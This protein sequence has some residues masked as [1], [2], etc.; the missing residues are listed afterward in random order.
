[1]G[2]SCMASIF[3]K[4]VDIP[5]CFSYTGFKMV[6][7]I[8]FFSLY[9]NASLN[10]SEMIQVLKW[11]RFYFMNLNSSRAYFLGKRNYHDA[12]SEKQLPVDVSSV[13]CSSQKVLY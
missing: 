3:L 2:I 10:G 4:L 13:L 7:S 5:C 11:Q 1:M 9:R 12:D 8:D 6:S